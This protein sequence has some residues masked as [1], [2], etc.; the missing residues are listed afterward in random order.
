MPG[1]YQRLGGDGEGNGSGTAGSAA[2]PPPGAVDSKVAQIID[3]G[4]ELEQ[5]N[6]RTENLKL[7]SQRFRDSSREI[8]SK[9]WWKNA[10]MTVILSVVG[11]IVVILIVIGV[12]KG[13]HVF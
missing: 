9:M 6:S 4:A 13:V 11:C 8:K 2:A 3:R 7:S 5:L 12:L 1:G 10:H